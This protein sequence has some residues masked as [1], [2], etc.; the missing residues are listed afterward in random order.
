MSEA[1]PRKKPSRKAGTIKS[2][3]AAATA[4]RKPARKIKKKPRNWKRWILP[5]V[6]LALAVYGVVWVIGYYHGQQEHARLDPIA[7]H[8]DHARARALEISRKGRRVHYEYLY[9]GIV[10]EAWQSD[11]EE[12]FSVG[13]CYEV[14]LDS[15]NPVRSYLVEGGIPCK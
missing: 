14:T 8:R 4:T 9:K 11:Y 10:Y 7:K 1:V 6:S 15:T 5:A 3:G 2:R 13:D 12:H